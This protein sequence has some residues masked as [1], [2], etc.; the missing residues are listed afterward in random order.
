MT[1]PRIEAA[2]LALLHSENYDMAGFAAETLRKALTSV[3]HGDCT[4]DPCACIRCICEQAK[5][6]A[7]AILAAADAAAWI[8]ISDKT[9]DDNQDVLVAT[10]ERIVTADMFNMDDEGGYFDITDDEEVTHW[11]PL[12]A[13]QGD[14][15]KV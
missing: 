1:D 15:V 3:H 12:P 11:Q 9:P 2:T 4:K 13:P 10:Y 14:E 7:S 6:G 5:S 8:K